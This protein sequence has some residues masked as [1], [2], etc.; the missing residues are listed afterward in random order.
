L[1]PSQ[2][3]DSSP[4]LTSGWRVW[5][6]VTGLLILP[7]LGMGAW[8]VTNAWSPIPAWSWHATQWSRQPWTWWTHAWVHLSP[9]H[10]LATVS[11]AA[12]LLALAREAG[13]TSG[14][15]LAWA[16][17]WG[18][19]PVLMPW[20]SV[21][22]S[23]GISAL[24]TVSGASGVLH[25]GVFIVAARLLVAPGRRQRAVGALLSLLLA[26]QLAGPYGPWRAHLDATWGFPV[27]HAAHQA[28]VL[29]AALAW[30]CVQAAAA[31]LHGL[32]HPRSQ[33]QNRRHESAH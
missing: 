10:L 16:L 21:P 27:A 29:A 5:C 4:G 30:V 6:I 19:G 2:D 8:E 25:A 23:P 9:A 12:I 28:G 17:A 11:G 24:T 14:D 3:A 7:A 32:Q 15:A 13:T 31:W 33:R 18:L 22:Q 20:L 26:L 1:K